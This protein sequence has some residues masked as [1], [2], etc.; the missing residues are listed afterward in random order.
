M[1]LKPVSCL[2]VNFSDENCIKL[3][4][5][6]YQIQRQLVSNNIW[7]SYCCLGQYCNLCSQMCN[8][9][10]DTDF[11]QH[12]T[13]PSN[14][15]DQQL[16]QPSSSVPERSKNARGA[17]I[18]CFWYFDRRWD[19]SEQNHDLDDS[20]M[21]LTI[22]ANRPKFN[23]HNSNMRRTVKNTSWLPGLP[24]AGLDSAQLLFNNLTF[25]QLQYCTL[26]RCFCDM[27]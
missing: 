6:T 13:W 19:D 21:S 26:S 3:L 7:S 11:V 14:T 22:Y 27:I 24:S 8:M 23:H 4:K 17:G 5:C 1:L 15:I 18:W 10:V 12:Q 16:F 9:W 25:K 2:Q 20:N